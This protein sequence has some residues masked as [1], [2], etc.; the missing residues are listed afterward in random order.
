MYEKHPSEQNSKRTKC[1]FG[2]NDLNMQTHLPK[3]LQRKINA[4]SQKHLCG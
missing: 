1:F 2:P 4:D 3:L